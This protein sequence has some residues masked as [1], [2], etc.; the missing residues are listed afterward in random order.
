MLKTV[1][2]TGRDQLVLLGL[3]I[4]SLDRFLAKPLDTFIAVQPGEIQTPIGIILFSARH[5]QEAINMV[6]ST[7]MLNSRVHVAPVVNA[8]CLIQN[9]PTLTLGF[10]FKDLRHLR[11]N[12]LSA[13]VSVT[14]RDDVPFT[15]R[16][17]SGPDLPSMQGM[18]K[19][20][21]LKFPFWWQT[22]HESA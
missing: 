22:Q 17:F 6:A 15:M 5:R 21:G 20:A 4:E 12:P 10:T 3:E 19:E 18:L 2:G 13:N 16:V 11:D 14:P 8:V 1:S 7:A 9:R